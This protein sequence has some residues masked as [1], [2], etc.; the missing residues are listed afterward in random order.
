MAEVHGDNVVVD[1]DKEASS[2]DWPPVGPHVATVM[3][4]DA[5]AAKTDGSPMLYWEFE[6]DSM[7]GTKYRRV[8]TNTSLKPQALWKLRDLVN[9][10][11]VFPGPD[12]FQR[13]AMVGKKLRIWIE[14]ESYC[15]QHNTNNDGCK[16]AQQMA[17]VGDYAPLA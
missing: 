9:A 17:K 16:D 4:C 15:K 13:S 12:G 11:G 3:K 1:F 14:H 6:V 8:W 10:C 7:D 2:G 5:Q